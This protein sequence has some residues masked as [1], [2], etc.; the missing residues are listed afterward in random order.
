MKKIKS[1]LIAVFLSLVC[2]FAVACGQ[3]QTGVYKTKSVT[4]GDV[5]VSVGEK[6]PGAQEPMNADFFVLELK[7]DNVA[8][9]TVADGDTVTIEGTWSQVGKNITLTFVE[10]GETI[11]IE[12]VQNGKEIT[13]DFI[14]EFIV[15]VE[16]Q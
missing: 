4:S 15:V 6:F 7:E 1:I 13:V 8:V 11:T 16:K 10:D 14:G 2:L 12:C 3:A 5:T 9:L